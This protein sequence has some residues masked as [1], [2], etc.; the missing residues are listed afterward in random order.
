MR[1]RVTSD[2]L[3]DLDDDYAFYE[4]QEKGIGSAH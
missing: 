4:K 2:A 3:D 1:I